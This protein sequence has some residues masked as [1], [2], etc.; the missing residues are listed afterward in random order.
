MYRPLD[1]DFQKSQREL[2][3]RDHRNV[4]GEFCVFT[5]SKYLLWA[6]ILQSCYF[7]VVISNQTHP[8]DVPPWCWQYPRLKELS[9]LFLTLLV[10][11][12]LC[13]EV[14][15]YG[16]IRSAN[17]RSCPRLTTASFPLQ[18]S[19][20]QYRECFY[21]LMHPL[22]LSLVTFI[23][24]LG[25]QFLLFLIFPARKLKREEKASE[26]PDIALVAPHFD[27]RPFEACGFATSEWSGLTQ[28]PSYLP[29]FGYWIYYECFI[30]FERWLK[31]LYFLSTFWPVL[32]KAIK[33]EEQGE[34]RY[35]DMRTENK[36]RIVF[37][38]QMT[39]YLWKYVATAGHQNENF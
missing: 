39:I 4:L 37:N 16:D 35:L 21:G 29:Q 8:A 14:M 11:A 36:L 32:L 23:K 38:T 3:I 33:G 22:P 18:V 15:K 9:A 20:W 2:P 6:E 34:I 26:R 30:F 27:K 12:S 13:R 7:N 24:N 19:Q 25:F 31:N 5:F 28:S 10:T 17:A 1:E